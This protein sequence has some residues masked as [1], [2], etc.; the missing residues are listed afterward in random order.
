[1]GGGEVDG[2]DAVVFPS[3]GIGASGK[4]EPQDVE[5][6]VGCGDVDGLA[7]HVIYGIDSDA[8][9]NELTNAMRLAMGD[10]E[11]KSAQR[12]VHGDLWTKLKLTVDARPKLK[13]ANMC[14]RVS[15]N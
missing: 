5:V 6:A 14:M 11:R 12:R 7:A 3:F 15:G 9:V 2:L 13:N 10:R 1:M 4:Q 8:L